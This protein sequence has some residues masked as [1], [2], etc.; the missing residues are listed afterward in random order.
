[1]IIIQ[2]GYTYIYADN[3]FLIAYKYNTLGTL[4]FFMENE[5]KIYFIQLN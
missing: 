5:S 1:M 4:L 2:F 3:K